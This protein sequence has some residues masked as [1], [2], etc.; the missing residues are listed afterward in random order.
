MVGAAVVPAIRFKQ[1]AWARWLSTAVRQPFGN[2][3]LCSHPFH[4][5]VLRWSYRHGQAIPVATHHPPCSFALLLLP[6]LKM[7]F[8]FQYRQPKW[9]QAIL[10]FLERALVHYI[11]SCAVE[12][13]F[14]IANFSKKETPLK[15]IVG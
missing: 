7:D 14:A 3:S 10:L 5:G 6:F 12:Q 11:N 8:A 2:S 9:V 13:H 15:H 4:P 1:R